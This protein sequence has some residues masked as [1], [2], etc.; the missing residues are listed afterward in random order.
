MADSAIARHA[1]TDKIEEILRK[2][3]GV[4]AS[5]VFRASKRR[6]RKKIAKE[7]L[8]SELDEGEC[9]AS[10]AP[11]PDVKPSAH[12]RHAY[13]MLTRNHI[14]DPECPD[15]NAGKCEQYVYTREDWNGDIVLH[16]VSA[17]L[18]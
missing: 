16:R 12:A 3:F 1:F 2:H 9:V 17:Q 5:D 13:R 8:I 7:S 11:V 6:A 14:S 15:C 10:W 18:N 4:L